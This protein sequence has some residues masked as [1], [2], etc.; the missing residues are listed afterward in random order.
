[1]FR[2][3]AKTITNRA[4]RSGVTKIPFRSMARKSVLASVL[5]VSIVSVNSLPKTTLGE[6]IAS[7]EENEK[8]AKLDE[9]NKMYQ[10]IAKCDKY[11][12]TKSFL[13]QFTVEPEYLN[14][15]KLSMRDNTV[16]VSVHFSSLPDNFRVS[17]VYLNGDDKYSVN[18]FNCLIRGQKGLPV[19]GVNAVDKMLRNLHNYKGT[20]HDAMRPILEQVCSH[21]RAYT[22]GYV[23]GQISG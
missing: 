2:R 11:D 17:F 22:S 15:S 9:K 8:K 18:G 16:Q 6:Y 4:I 3:F 21:E 1:M 13:E 5:S 14:T 23:L 10:E 7:V 19:E 20:T 12:P